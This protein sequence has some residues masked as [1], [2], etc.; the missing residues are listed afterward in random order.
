VPCQDLLILSNKMKYDYGEEE[1]VM[2]AAACLVLSCASQLSVA[3]MQRSQ[4]KH[5]I[6][7]FD[8]L[9]QWQQD[10][11]YQTLLREL[12]KKKYEDKFISYLRVNIHDFEDLK[13]LSAKDKPSFSK[14]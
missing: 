8:Y 3:M 7:V 14:T 6:W 1:D 9:C 10:G 13:L 11:V 12:S 2:L 5:S 4:R